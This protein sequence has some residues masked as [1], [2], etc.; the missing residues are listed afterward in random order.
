MLFK[1]KSKKIHW[2]GHSSDVKLCNLFWEICYM[3]SGE[4]FAYIFDH[5]LGFGSIA[6]SQCPGSAEAFSIAI[7][8]KFNSV[9]LFVVWTVEESWWLETF[10]RSWCDLSALPIPV[11]NMCWIVRLNEAADGVSVDCYDFNVF[12][13]CWLLL[14]YN[15][16]ILRLNEG[17]WDVVPV[18]S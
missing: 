13:V 16:E 3:S 17:S 8:R 12:R 14:Q 18:Q 15:K 6:F 10:S 4:M 7:A 2:L 9:D 5:L 1:T 11:L